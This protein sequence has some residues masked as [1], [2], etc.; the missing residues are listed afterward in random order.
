[1]DAQRLNPRLPSG[2][3]EDADDSLKEGKADDFAKFRSV[4]KRL[5]TI[6]GVGDNPMLRRKVYQKIQRAAIEY[7]PEC[8]D[9][10]KLAVSAAQTADK[11]DRYFVAAI[12]RELKVLEM[13]EKSSD[14]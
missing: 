7:G 11:P 4:A 12:T 8:Y 2:T 13:W 10:I 3:D 5:E 14:F 9:V 6:Y 1:M